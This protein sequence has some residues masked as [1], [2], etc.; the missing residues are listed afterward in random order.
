[1]SNQENKNLE[2][3]VNDNSTKVEWLGID[4]ALVLLFIALAFFLGFCVIN[5]VDIVIGI[6]LP[7]GVTIATTGIFIRYFWEVVA[8]SKK[9]EK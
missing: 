4:G 7:Y 9:N 8:F 3:E 5:N 2:P 1:M 6:I